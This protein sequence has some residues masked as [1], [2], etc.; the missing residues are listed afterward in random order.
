MDLNIDDD[1]TPGR[2]VIA[3]RDASNVNSSPEPNMAEVA[4]VRWE[5]EKS[6]YRGKVRF[7]LCCC[8]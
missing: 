6:L 4:S 3:G 5:P 1:V 8:Q 7:C 2:D